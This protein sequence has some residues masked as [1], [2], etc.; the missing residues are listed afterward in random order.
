MDRKPRRRSRFLPR[1]IS[2]LVSLIGVVALFVMLGQWYVVHADASGTYKSS[3]NWPIVFVHGL[4]QNNSGVSCS[5]TWGTAENY[6]RGS[7]SVNG[8]NITWTGSLRTVGYYSN[9]T[10][11]D[12]SLMSYSSHCNGYYSS[13]IGT[14]NE[15]IRHLGC[16]LAWY[17]YATW[18]QYGQSVQAVAHSMGGLIVRYALYGTHA[19]LG[20]VFPPV[21]YIQD[22]VTFSTPH[23]GV[24]LGSSL[25]D[26]GNCAEG[27]EMTSGSS[28]MNEMY[29]SAQNPQGGGWGT[30]WTMMGGKAIYQLGCDYVSYGEATY[31]NLGHKS[32]F[33]LPCYSHGGYLT[34][35]NDASDAHIYWCD[36]CATA[37]SS[38]NYWGGAPHSLR[39]MLFALYLSSW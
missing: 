11:C 2:I 24:P 30:D 33:T 37:P 26:C 3:A 16:E 7:H 13:G 38:W 27:Q 36:G 31:M 10:S 19:H 21:L 14:N 5:G 25:I 29:N 17:I 22:V 9:D 23:G 4:S 8:H 35:T 6:L 15:S 32:Y 34:D 28:F 12:L 1:R 39:H 20:G 18:S